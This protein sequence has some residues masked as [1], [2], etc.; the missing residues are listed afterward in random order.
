MS[1][2]TARGTRTCSSSAA[3]ADAARACASASAIAATSRW[4]SGRAVSSAWCSSRSSPRRTSAAA[5]AASVAPANAASC[6]SWISTADFAAAARCR[7]S[8][9]DAVV[10]L[11]V[12]ELGEEVAA[13]RRLVVQEAGEL[14][15]REHDALGEVRERE[16]EQPLDGG[17][18]LARA[19]RRGRSRGPSASMPF[20]ERFGR[21]RLAVA[22]AHDPGRPVLLLADGER[23]RDLGFLLADADDARDLPLV[24]VAGHAAVQGEAERVD[25]GRLARAGRP[26]RARSSRRRRSRCRPASRKTPNPSAWSVSGRISPALPRSR[27]RTAVR[28]GGRRARRRRPRR[29]RYSVNRSRG[30]AAAAHRPR[31]TVRRRVELAVDADVDRAGQ[32]RAHFV[33]EAGTGR[34]RARRR[35]TTRRRPCRAAARSSSSVPRTVRSVH[36]VVSSRTST[37]AGTPASASTTQH[38]LRVLLLAEVDLDRRARVPGRRGRGHALG[39]VQVPERDV[40]RVPREVEASMP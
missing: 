36:G 21:A 40:V 6:R 8:C 10:D 14:A 38:V 28:T 5:R 30:R 15:L 20:E 37:C 19:A 9:A 34:A 33:G 35:A 11:E 16:A 31:F 26:D 32:Q 13:L 22:D 23:E 27:R 24:A 18:Q 2:V 7:A 3:S 12:E 39:A 29:S 1:C 25:H 4:S 17:L